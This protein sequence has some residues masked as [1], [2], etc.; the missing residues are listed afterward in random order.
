MQVVKW[1]GAIVVA[2][3]V[4]GVII[5]AVMNYL[6]GARLANAPDI[7]V[8]A[9]TVPTDEQ[10]I[11][12][13]EHFVHNISVCTEC[14]GDDLGGKVMINEAPIGYVPAPNLTAGQGGVG[15]AYTDEDWVR[16]LRHGVGKQGQ[17]L[18]VMPS[19][20]FT[21]LTDEDLA[22]VI[23]YVKQVDPVDNDLGPRKIQFPGTILMGLLGYNDLPIAQIDHGNAGSTPSAR[24]VNKEYG[25]Y[26][27]KI[28][29]C[30]DCHG[31]NLAGNPSA[32]GAPMG[33]N[34]TPGGKLSDFNEAQ[35]IAF[36]R[37][38]M[39]PEGVQVSDEMPWAYYQGMTDDELRAIWAELSTLEPLPDN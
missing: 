34:I 5:G 39:T 29:G 38:G 22:A 1:V 31:V 6:G 20:A 23:A 14:H 17:T 26:L 18:V 36:M 19:Q 27:V 25:G 37:S 35:F 7:N 12:N 30:A 8:E 24:R 11:A 13:G 2:V 32:N 15:S 10:S 9:I 3:L 21:N 4:V 28:A 16:T 33:P